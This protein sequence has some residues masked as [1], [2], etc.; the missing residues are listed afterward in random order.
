MNRKKLTWLTSLVVIVG[1]FYTLSSALAAT[2]N[3]TSADL[4]N[5]LI[6]ISGQAFGTTR[7]SVLLGTTTL[8]IV[9]WSKT[10]IVADLPAGVTPG[11]YLL[12]VR[13]LGNVVLATSNIT[14]GAQGL[15]GPAGPQ[16]QVG[17]EGPVEPTGP[18]GVANGISVAVHGTVDST[19]AVLSGKGFTV[20][21]IGHNMI[22]FN[23]AFASTPECTVQAYQSQDM[24]F[25]NCNAAYVD[26]NYLQV[27]CQQHQPA[28]NS[29][30]NIVM[31]INNTSNTVAYTFICVE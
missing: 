12:K 5:G 29:S 17:P 25:Y 11:T 30:N 15:Q 2:I 9:S 27:V 22:Y 3:E 23:S 28:Y 1:V 13:G 16:G 20:G 6:T 7:H 26:V 8:T 4:T 21:G 24:T 19:G 18:A 31:L 10:Q 14:I